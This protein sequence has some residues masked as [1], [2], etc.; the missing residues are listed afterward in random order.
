MR[1]VVTGSRE[2]SHW[3]AVWMMLDALQ[4]SILGVGDCP[5]GA[6]HHTREWADQHMKHGTWAVYDAEWNKH[7]RRAGPLRNRRMIDE[8]RPALVLAFPTQS[9]R[10]TWDCAEYARGQGIRVVVHGRGKRWTG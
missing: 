1:I 3:A 5:T 2:W 9:S 8:V 10:G 7:G 4:P 6:D